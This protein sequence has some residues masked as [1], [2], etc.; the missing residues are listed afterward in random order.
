[1]LEIIKPTAKRRIQLGNNRG[2]TISARALGPHPNA[3][4]KRCAALF[5]YPASPHFEAIAQK[6]KALPVLPTVTHV[7]F[8][9][10][11]TQSV[12]FYPTSYFFKRGLRLFGCLAKHHKV[13]GVANHA[14]A[15]LLH[16]TVQRVKIDISQQRTDHRSLRCAARWRPSLHL[17]DDVLLKI[18]FYQLKHPPIAHLFLH[19][20]QKPRMCNGVE[21]ALKIGIHYKGVAFSKQPF[22]FTK[23]IFAVK[24]RAK[25]VTHLK[26]LP[27]K[28]RLQHKL[29]CRL[30]DTVFDHRNPQRTKL[31]APF[32]NL[33]SSDGLWPVGS[34]L[35][36]CAQFLQIHLRPCRKSLHTLSVNS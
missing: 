5:P 23:R 33:H 12:L 4:S 30:N 35:K 31:P 16:M 24:S 2:Q 13:I 32:G 17:L 29:K 28:D 22:H 1:M 3:I 9:D 20:L 7:G 8:I 6:L 15:L 34:L 21:V 26:E 18:R 14:V 19:A 25:A 11:K 36:C 10:T 27:L